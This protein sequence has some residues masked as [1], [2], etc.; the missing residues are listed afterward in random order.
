MERQDDVI[1]ADGPL[2]YRYLTLVVSNCMLLKAQDLPDD[3]ADGNKVY[4]LI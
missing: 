1:G 3:K 2:R 4:A